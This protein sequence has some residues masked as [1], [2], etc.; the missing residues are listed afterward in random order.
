MNVNEYIESGILD[1]YVLGGLSPEEIT[2][3]EAFATKFPEIGKEIDSIRSTIEEMSSVDSIA[4][5]YLNKQKLFNKIDLLPAAQEKVPTSKTIKFDIKPSR[6]INFVYF[7]I[8]ASWLLTL[9]SGYF[10]FHYRN[11]WLDSE[12]KILALQNENKDLA[13]NF[14]VTKSSYQA[15]SNQLAAINDSSLKMI[16][17]KALPGR[18]AVFAKILWSKS[19]HQVLLSSLSLP[20]APE[21]KQYQLWAIVDGKPVDA[22]VISTKDTQQLSRMKDISNPSAFAV[23]LEK[24]G[25]SEVPTMEEMYVI[26]R[27]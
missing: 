1:V 21:G 20:K 17:L 14:S 15:A 6:N 26:G 5:S 13:T 10:A 22:G 4:P 8:A 24:S 11:Q 2:E 9:L 27:I 3:V 12:N 19:K 25:G 7:A 23:T 16:T 18:P